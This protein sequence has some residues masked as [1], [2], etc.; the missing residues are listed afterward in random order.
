MT[1]NDSEYDNLIFQ[2]V[3][4]TENR[5]KMETINIAFI[6][7]A[8]CNDCMA[9]VLPFLWTII[10]HT[11]CKISRKSVKTRKCICL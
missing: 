6:N 5:K 8:N 7:C 10:Q 1:M 3:K 11:T 9:L 2:K 4:N